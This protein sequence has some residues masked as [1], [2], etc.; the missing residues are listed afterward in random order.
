MSGTFLGF[1]FGTKSIGRGG[2]T[3]HHRD[4]TTITG[5]EGA[6]R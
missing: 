5:A 2:G 3:T 1:D 6:G 4:R